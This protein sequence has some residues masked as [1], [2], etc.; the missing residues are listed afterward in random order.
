M[1]RA[2]LPGMEREHIREFGASGA[3]NAAPAQS[4]CT[5]FPLLGLHAVGHARSPRKLIAPLHCDRRAERIAQ[6]LLMR[7][8]PTDVE[9]LARRVAELIGAM[10]PPPSGQLLDAVQLARVLGVERDCL[11]AR[12][13]ARQRPSRSSAPSRASRPSAFTS[14]P[15]TASAKRGVD[16]A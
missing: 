11:R 15:A 1:G 7:L 13:R 5:Q 6:R 8:H 9:Q 16:P 14:T 2:H 10:Q 3:A 12:S 4:A